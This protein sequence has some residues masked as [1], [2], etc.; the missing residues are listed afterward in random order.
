MA[1]QSVSRVRPGL[2]LLAFGI[3]MFIWIAGTGQSSIEQAFSV[4]I[5]LHGVKD[6]LVVT[7]QNADTVSI[8]VRGSRAALSNIQ[9]E[10]LKYVIDVSD[11]KPGEAEYQVQKSLIPGIPRG[12]DVTAISPSEILVD[13]ERRG[14][15]A[16]GIR[17]DLAGRPAPGFHIADVEIAPRRVWLTGARS[18]VLRLTEV[19]TEPIDVS[20]LDES[21]ER[22]A[23]LFLGAGNVWREDD[24]PVTIT[25][26]VEA[27]SLPEPSVD[28][29][30]EENAATQEQVTG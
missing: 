30:G 11:A 16:V 3:A 25:I 23:S 19:V 26:R 24:R 20:G 17:V 27:D 12:P 1:K 9:S 14:R 2:A 10:K 7:D 22:E 28:G 6:D 15:K 5:E 29:L 13:F 18:Q 4:P 8:R 21:D